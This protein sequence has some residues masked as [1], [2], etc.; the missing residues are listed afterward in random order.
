MGNLCP[1]LTEVLLKGIEAE[2]RPDDGLLHCS[3]DSWAP[4]RFVQLKQVLPKSDRN[5]IGD[6]ITLHTGTLWHKFLEEHVWKLEETKTWEWE[7][8]DTEWDVTPYLPTGWTGTAD[9]VLCHK[10]S[11]DADLPCIFVGDMKTAKPESLQW[12]DGKPK[13]EHLTQVSCYHAAVDKFYDDEGYPRNMMPHIGVFYLPKGKTSRGE[14]VQP[15]TLTAPAIK[16][17][18]IFRR[19]NNIRHAVEQYKAEVERTGNL[20]N[21]Y[22]APMPEPELKVEWDK[23]QY[24]WHVVQRPHWHE[25]YLAP[26]DD[27]VLCPKTPS[28]R[29]GRWTLDGHWIARPGVESPDCIIPQPSRQEVER[30]RG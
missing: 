8:I 11:S 16:R 29:I 27:P 18:V 7:V 14:T 4:L 25:T 19:L 3:S 28:Q 5:D 1:D 9:L 10:A 15:V 24:V 22:L 6:L 21:D 2:Q 12:L 20:L 13:D 17:D 23:T 26:T 30:R